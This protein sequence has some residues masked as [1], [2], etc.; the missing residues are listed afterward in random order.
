[1]KKIIIIVSVLI[2]LSGGAY[3]YLNNLVDKISVEKF[4]LG[5]AV[6][7]EQDGFSVPVMLSIKNLNKISFK[8]KEVWVMVIEGTTI[9]A[10]STDPQTI[11]INANSVTELSHRMTV[12]SI[13]RI[14]QIAL[15]PGITPLKIVVNF[16]VFGFDFSKTFT[17]T[18]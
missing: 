17:Q 12:Y 10:K 3:W 1:M 4:D 11:R 13:K 15:N 8:I 16:S 9:L 2:G 5:L 14:S 6:K 18:F 7:S